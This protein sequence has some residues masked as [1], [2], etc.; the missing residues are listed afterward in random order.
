MLKGKIKVGDK[1]K[2]LKIGIALG[3]GAA[4]GLAH[5]GVLQ[6]LKEEKIPIDVIAGTSIG[7][8]IGAFY[9]AGTDL[10]LLGKLA[11]QIGWRHLVDLKFC[12]NGLINGREI[13]NFIRLLTQNK[14]FSELEIPFA[15]VAADLQRGEEVI[16][17]EGLVAEAV[18]ASISLP[19]V[20]VPAEIG[21]RLLVDGG[22]VSR[23][24]VRAAK[25][26]GANFIIGVDLPVDLTANRTT[27]MLEIIL[28]TIS[29]MDCE[30]TKF[31]ATEADLIITPAVQDISLTALQRSQECI[32]L[33]RQ[34]ALESL[35]KINQLISENSEK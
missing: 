31:K 14:D 20:F 23:L 34:A 33:G 12:K 22:V 11:E 15:A 1:M 10:Y 27:N 13:F 17:R 18:R 7:S 8:M 29:I 21:G 32:E 3:A 26:L 19:G 35:P 2:K 9:A 28:Q 5:I 30:I 24:P 4:R 16:L 6:V 25:E